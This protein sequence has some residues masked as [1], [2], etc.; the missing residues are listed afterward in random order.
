M[1]KTFFVLLIIILVGVGVYFFVIKDRADSD[2][3]TVNWDNPE[4]VFNI[5]IPANFDEFK[6][7]RLEEKIAQAR[8]L[9][10]E[11]FCR[12]W[13]FY[14]GAAELGF[15]HGSNMVFQLLLTK[16][17]DAVPLDRNFIAE[18][19]GNLLHGSK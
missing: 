6:K 13:E 15:L 18:A 17:R 3:L 8:E 4:E 7:E 11:R 2:A 14:L 5:D 10:D 1:K 19:E 9:Y 16:E 12:M